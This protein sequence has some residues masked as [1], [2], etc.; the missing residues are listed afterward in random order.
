MSGCGWGGGPTIRL[1]TKK[2]RGE[3]A[4][5]KNEKG[6]EDCAEDMPHQLKK[7]VGEEN[8]R[9]GRETNTSAQQIILLPLPIGQKHA[10]H[11]NPQPEK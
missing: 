9:G 1:W 11:D 2:D 8:V 6:G 7:G 10:Q 5:H 4:N 3:I